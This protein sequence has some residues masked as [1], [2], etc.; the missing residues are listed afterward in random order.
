MIDKVKKRQ[1]EVKSSHG[2]LRF[3]P[4]RLETILH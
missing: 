4:L 1:R 2:L 3:K